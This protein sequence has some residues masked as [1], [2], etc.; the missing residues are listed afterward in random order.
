MT[1][2]A[3]AEAQVV[4]AVLA[5]VG[6]LSGLWVQ[7]RRV[8]AENRA[9]HHATAAK[10]D[11]LVTFVADLGLD[12]REIKADVRDLKADLRSHGDRIKRLEH[13]PAAR[14]PR[15]KKEAPDGP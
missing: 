4:T 5:L 8:H 12:A 1:G 13:R 15:P 11:T 6:V 7:S 3:A 14:V 9:D 2:I 10:V